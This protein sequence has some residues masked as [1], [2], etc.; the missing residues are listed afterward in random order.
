M[1]DDNEL[2]PRLEASLRNISAPDPSVME[3]HIA[4]A[5]GE[6]AAATSRGRLRF[7]AI[8]AAVLVLVSG[9]IAVAKNSRDAPPAI[10]ADTTVT[11]VPK[12][13]GA[14]THSGGFWGDV[15]GIDYFTLRG[16]AF[17]LVHRDDLVDLYFGSKPCT[18]VGTIAYYE[19]ML[20]RDKQEESPSETTCEQKPLIQFTDN[21]GGSEYRLA[22][23][24]TPAG[25]SLF[26]EDRCNEPLGSIA[27]PTSGD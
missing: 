4:A 19:A 25:V 2:D 12:A 26:F 11:T 9:G 21:A 18:M 13:S 16:T 15:G 1:S 3:T 20:R 8:A 23:L 5:L 7:L 14:C 27:L 22:L 10:A 6:V 17:E 24:E